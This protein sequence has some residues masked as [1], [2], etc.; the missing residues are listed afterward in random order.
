MFFLMS[1]KN[2][3]DES[4]VWSIR[5]ACEQLGQCVCDEILAIHNLLGCDTTSKVLSIGKGAALTKFQ[6]G[7]YFQQDILLFLK[8]MFQKQKLKK[9]EKDY[10]YLCMVEKRITLWIEY[11]FINF[12][13]R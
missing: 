3:K 4:K 5:F 13:K 7:E 2:V 6:K 10:W 1:D 12:I 11:V 8:K 9:P